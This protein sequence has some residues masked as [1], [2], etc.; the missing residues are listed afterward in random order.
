M[1][2]LLSNSTEILSKSCGIA[3]RKP[4]GKPQFYSDAIR[5]TALYSVELR[6]G[7]LAQGIYSP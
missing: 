3:V 2:F 5:Y 7:T 4:C 1:K 6:N